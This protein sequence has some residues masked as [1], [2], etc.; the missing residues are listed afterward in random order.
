LSIF[1]SLRK[2]WTSHLNI[3]LFTRLPH[4]I[5]REISNSKIISN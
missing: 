1:L 2:S 5:T 4:R 3:K